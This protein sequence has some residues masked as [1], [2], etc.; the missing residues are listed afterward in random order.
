MIFFYFKPLSPGENHARDDREK[1][2]GEGFLKLSIF[3][4]IWSGS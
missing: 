4:L 1:D 2:I 3:K